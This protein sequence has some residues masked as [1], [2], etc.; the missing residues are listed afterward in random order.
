[1]NTTSLIKLTSSAIAIATATLFSSCV[2]PV[3]QQQQGAV[4]QPQAGQ[5]PYAVPGLNGQNQAPPVVGNPSYP[6]NQGTAPYQPLPGVPSD[7]AVLPEPSPAIPSAPA[8]PSAATSHDVVAGESLWR[9]SRKY[10]VTVDALK[11]ANGLKNDTIWAGQKLI[12]PAG[13]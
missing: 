13:N 2:Q 8:Q 5:N 3:G 1:M 11:E 9:I 10:G 7:P 12:I 4:N 6:Q